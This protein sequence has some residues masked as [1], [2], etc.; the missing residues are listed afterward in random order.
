M[1]ATRKNGYKLIA[2]SAILLGAGCD[3]SRMLTVTLA[4]AIQAR[5]R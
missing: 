3:K 2:I 5:S 4:P 1:R